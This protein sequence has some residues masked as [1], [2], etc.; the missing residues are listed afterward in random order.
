MIRRTALRAA[1][2]LMLVGLLGGCDTVDWHGT[3]ERWID[4][5]CRTDKMD[6]G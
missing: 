4:S 2:I 3:F 1:A 5:L 6:C